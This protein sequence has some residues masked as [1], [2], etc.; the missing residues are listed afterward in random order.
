MVEQYAQAQA[1]AAGLVCPRVG[2][3]AVGPWA[4]GPWA[5]RVIVNIGDAH[6]WLPKPGSA[7]TAVANCC[8]RSA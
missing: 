6:T 3:W 2:P 1:L 5:G 4:V 8:P 7:R